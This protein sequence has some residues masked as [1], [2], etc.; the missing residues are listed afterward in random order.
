[1]KIGFT[2]TRTGATHAQLQ[3]ITRFLTEL[4]APGS[5]FHYGD[6]GKADSQA[7]QIARGLGYEI[8]AHPSDLS[9]VRYGTFDVEYPPKPPLDRN[10]DIVDAV[11]ALIVV[12]RSRKE[13]LRSGTW[14]TWR[15][16]NRQTGKRII[17]INP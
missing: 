14:A 12:P 7:S 11:Y 6:G 3:H 1:M 9:G 5:Q 8:H 17:V 13:E 10:H 16:A 2:G 4:Y 15:Y